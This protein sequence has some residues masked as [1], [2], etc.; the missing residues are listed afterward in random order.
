[1]LLSF[2]YHF[3]LSIYF[4]YF[5]LLWAFVASCRLSL[6]ALSWGYSSLWYLVFSLWWILLWSTG[7]RCASFSICS[8]QAQQL[9][10]TGLVSLWP[11]GSS[12][13]RDWTRVFCSGRYILIYCATR[14]VGKV[15][16]PFILT[17]ILWSRLYF[18]SS[19]HREAN[20]NIEWINYFPK[21]I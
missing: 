1:M 20:Q 17:D 11:V 8:T 12:R 14:G 16:F 6:V 5:W 15:T 3:Y 19:F 21:V 9:W 10:H 18:L 4:I 7:S 13:T 2:A